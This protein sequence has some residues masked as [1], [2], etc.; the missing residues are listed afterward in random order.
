MS[1]S[2]INIAIN[3]VLGTNDRWVLVKRD[4]YYRTNGCGY[5][6]SIGEAWILTEREADRHVYPHDEPVTKHRAPLTDYANSLDAMHEAESEIKGSEQRA[7]YA[8]RVIEILNR[9]HHGEH[10]FIGAS[11]FCRIHATAAQRAES[12]LR[13]KGLWK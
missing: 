6:N 3:E 9:D 1:P 2:E 5:T 4:L 10:R 12:F 7:Q 11:D 8:E 13:V